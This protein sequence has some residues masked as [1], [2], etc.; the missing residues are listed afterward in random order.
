MRFLL[1]LL[2]D[3]LAVVAVAL[4]T[5]ATYRAWVARRQARLCPSCQDLALLRAHDNVC[6]GCGQLHLGPYDPLATER[7]DP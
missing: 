6:P 5:R 3:L 1:I 7:I 4:I 2:G